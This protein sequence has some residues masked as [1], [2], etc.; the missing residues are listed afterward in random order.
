M[1]LLVM[2]G[3]DFRCLPTAQT[4]ASRLQK[5]WAKFS[6][7]LASNAAT[8]DIGI[9]TRQPSAARF[10]ELLT[11]LMRML[12]VGVSV[13]S[14][15]VPLS[16]E[17]HL[18]FGVIIF[19]LL[20]GYLSTLFFIQPFKWAEMN[21]FIFVARLIGCVTALLGI[22]TI[23]INDKS[24]I[25]TGVAWYCSM[26]LIALVGTRIGRVLMAKCKCGYEI[27]G[28]LASTKLW[29]LLGR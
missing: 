8:I 7:G 17:E 24:V 19:V 5:L 21:A 9:L 26:L 29:P 25:W 10:D 18:L 1:I 16:R 13:G 2:A 15:S 20:V 4:G 28:T 6:N 23:A 3:G 14:D 11:A 12:L 22:L 27:S